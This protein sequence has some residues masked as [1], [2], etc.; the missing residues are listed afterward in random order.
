MGACKL[1][2][3]RKRLSSAGAIDDDPCGSANAV[4]VEANAQIAPAKKSET[5]R[6]VNKI[7]TGLFNTSGLR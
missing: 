7:P 1:R 4:D 5:V 6:I 2:E 3:G